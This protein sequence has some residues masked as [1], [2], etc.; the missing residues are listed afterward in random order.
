MSAPR[1]HI[2]LIG[3]GLVGT[4]VARRLLAAGFALT[5]YDA[6]PSRVSLLTSIGVVAADSPLGVAACC[7]RVLLA[8][9]DTAAV[10]QVLV[11]FVQL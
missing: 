5:G 2:G 11:V 4:A 8:V 6:D 3:L 1:T 9:Y 7:E 10:E